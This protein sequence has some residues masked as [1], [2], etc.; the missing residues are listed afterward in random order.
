M[1]SSRVSHD[2]ASESLTR[3]TSRRTAILVYAALA[4]VVLAC[5]VIAVALERRTASHP[6]VVHLVVPPADDA[7]VPRPDPALLRVCADPNDLP[8]S[9]HAGEGFENAIAELPVSDAAGR[10]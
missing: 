5:T 2:I 6:D 1:R 8:Y 10:E 7:D 9:N 3:H 4:L